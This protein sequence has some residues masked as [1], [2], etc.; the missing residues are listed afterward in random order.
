MTFYGRIT[1]YM[2]PGPCRKKS[3]HRI[4]YSMVDLPHQGYPLAGL[5]NIGPRDIVRSGF[6]FW[7]LPHRPGLTM[8]A[9]ADHTKHMCQISWD[10]KFVK[11]DRT[12]NLSEMDLPGVE[13]VPRPCRGILHATRASRLPYRAKS[14]LSMKF[15][16]FIVFSLLTHL[17]GPIGHGGG[18]RNFAGWPV[19]PDLKL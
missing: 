18:P 13:I 5:P 15:D 10:D 2:G 12:N 6:G 16:I 9:L 19:K 7:F 8:I 11:N 14:D 4:S 17:K 3:Y 1:S